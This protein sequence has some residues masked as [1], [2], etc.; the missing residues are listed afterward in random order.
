MHSQARAENLRQN[1]KWA[2]ITF[3]ATMPIVYGMFWYVGIL[4]DAL[5]SYSKRD[6][7]AAREA[8]RARVEAQWGTNK[9]SSPPPQP[10]V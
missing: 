1:E 9:P 8:A 7:D 2:L 5:E 10:G 4:D 3:V 6:R